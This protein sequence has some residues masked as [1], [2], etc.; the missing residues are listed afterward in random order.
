MAGAREERGG[1]YWVVMGD[2]REGDVFLVYW[3]GD[4][5]RPGGRMILWWRQQKTMAGEEGHL[6]TG[7]VGG[8]GPR[9]KLSNNKRRSLGPERSMS[10]VG[11]PPPHNL[12]KPRKLVASNNNN[13]NK[14]QGPYII[15]RD[16]IKGVCLL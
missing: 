10:E 11:T 1:R 8:A 12:D 16:N 3:D 4:R 14:S 2:R 5:R 9:S 7:G 6:T 15:V 13:N